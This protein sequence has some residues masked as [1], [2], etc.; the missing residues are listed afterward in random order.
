MQTNAADPRQIREA[1]QTSR[2]I[3]KQE[4]KD[5]S[6]ILS[7]IEGRRF[8]FRYLCEC[9]I[10]KTSFTGSSETFFREGQRNVG[11]SLLADLNDADPTMYAKIMEENRKVN[12]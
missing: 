7:T 12:E 6:L 1:K 5:V 8:F 9:G 4:L 3:R 10:F 2:E 11:L